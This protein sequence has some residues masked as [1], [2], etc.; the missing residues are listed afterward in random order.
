VAYISLKDL[1]F[2]DVAGITVPP[3]PRQQV[4]TPPVKV[5]VPGDE[6]VPQTP[7]T[8]YD[9]SPDLFQKTAGGDKEGTGRGEYSIACILYGFKTKE[10]VDKASGRIIQ[11]GGAS[12]DVVGPD[13]RKYEVKELT[14]AVRTGTEGTG[15]FTDILNSTIELLDAI[16]KEFNTLD[17]QG[18]QTINNMILNSNTVKSTIL[19]RKSQKGH[20]DAIKDRWSLDEYLNDIK[21]KAPRE[22]SKG[23]LISPILNLGQY[24][25]ERPY[26][27]FSLKQLVDVLNEIA[28]TQVATGNEEGTLN[29]AVK[30]ISDTINKHY[31]VQ[32]DEKE[33]EFFKKEAEKIDRA[34][35]QKRCKEFKK[36]T[37]ELS[38]RK[39]IIALNLTG[40]LKLIQDKTQDIVE[41]LFPND[42]LFAVNSQGFQYI[43]HSKLNTYLAFD[44]ISSGSVKIKQKIASNET[45]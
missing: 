20:F 4:N 43:P 45:V 24:K 22:L 3:L 9:I 38:F 33:K 42:G 2:E 36:C 5:F 12:F 32:G 35:I 28:S 7:W 41:N 16:L 30:D 26:V 34:L 19:N 37:D 18:K 15:V 40:M 31:K 44:T 39:Q 13:K 29:P 27:I 1:Y 8:E 23:I 21:R 14:K 10:Q 17:A 6:Y 11:G 25:E